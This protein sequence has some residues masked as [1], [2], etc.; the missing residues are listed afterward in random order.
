MDL[1]K[2]FP[3]G[4][5]RFTRIAAFSND[6]FAY[7]VTPLVRE[8]KVPSLKDCGSVNEFGSAAFELLP[9]PIALMGEWST[10][11]LAMSLFGTVTAFNML[12]FMAQQADIL[13]NLFSPVILTLHHPAVRSYSI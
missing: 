10:N 3:Y 2:R 11:P 1:L 12:L 4:E 6:A 5:V 8:L 9:F 13:V 7:V